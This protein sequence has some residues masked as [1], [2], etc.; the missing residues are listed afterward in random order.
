MKHML[1]KLSMVGILI[2]PTGPALAKTY[3]F[4]CKGP[5]ADRVIPTTQ[6]NADLT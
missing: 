3:Y 6:V 1:A 5:G 4:K 2:G